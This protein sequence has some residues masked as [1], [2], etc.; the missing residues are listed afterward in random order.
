METALLVAFIAAGTT[1]VGTFINFFSM[2]LT[3]WYEKNSKVQDW[4][5]SKR[6]ASIESFSARLDGITA[7]TNRTALEAFQIFSLARE[8]VK[9]YR[10]SVTVKSDSSQSSVNTGNLLK[11]NSELVDMIT[12]FQPKVFQ[13]LIRM[14][15]WEKHES[16]T[17]AIW[18]E[19]RISFLEQVH[20]LAVKNR[21]ALQ[22]AYDIV[23]A[24]LHISIRVISNPSYSESKTQA[25]EAELEVLGERLS[26][27]TKLKDDCAIESLKVQANLARD[28]NRSTVS[29]KDFLREAFSFSNK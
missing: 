14:L 13:M 15:D 27:L 12:V 17:L 20:P 22:S 24:T 1:L 11:K 5:L 29:L 19:N 6:I 21:A 23:S 3:R 18:L 28:M 2:L 7:D 10:S 9:E 26:V 4:M 16:A 8:M 25:F